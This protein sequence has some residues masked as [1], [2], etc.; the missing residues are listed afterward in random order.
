[1]SEQQ[2][3]ELIERYVTMW[4]EREATR[5]DATGGVVATDGEMVCGS[6]TISPRLV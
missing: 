3:N 6:R 1:M 4:H 5:R 2:L